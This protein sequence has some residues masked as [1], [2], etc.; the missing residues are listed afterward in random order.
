MPDPSRLLIV[1]HGRG[2]GRDPENYDAALARTFEE[3]PDVAARCDVWHTGTPPPS[4]DAYRTVLCLLADPL[5]EHFPDCYAEAHELTERARAAGAGIVNPPDAL[6]NTI[7]SRQAELWEAAGIPQ[8]RTLG[9]TDEAELAT[10]AD[11]LRFPVIVRGDDLHDHAATATFA[12]RDELDA[13]ELPYPGALSELIDTRRG[14]TEPALSRLFHKC[15]AFV[16]GDHVRTHHL[17]L[18]EDPIVSMSSSLFKV[19]YRP[20]SRAPWTHLARRRWYRRA[21]EMDL[22]YFHEPEPQAD[23][24]RRAVHTLGL[25]F[26]AVDYARLGDGSLLLFEANPYFTFPATA[27]TPLEAPRRMLERRV[28]Y[29][30]VLA[31]ALRAW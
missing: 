12:S 8:A 31:D 25:G 7:K 9:Y 26:A 6:S 15:R 23:L 29:R 3:H 2:R 13:T 14:H 10:V 19:P 5:R 1:R 16:F 24:L 30:R 4:A 28:E 17:A 11:G 22:A 27:H 18:A 21:I 20:R